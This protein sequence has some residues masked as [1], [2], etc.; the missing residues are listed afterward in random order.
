MFIITKF[1]M[2]FCICNLKLKLKTN[3]GSSCNS[4]VF[5]FRDGSRYCKNHANVGTE[6]HFGKQHEPSYSY[7]RELRTNQRKD[8]DSSSSPKHHSTTI[9][10]TKKETTTSITIS[11]DDHLCNFF[12]FTWAFVQ[13]E[14]VV[15]QLLFQLL[16][17]MIVRFY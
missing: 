7:C 14:V 6:R 1:I 8:Q 2:I 17:V 5:N 3:S 12:W 13:E 11:N 4:M 15:Y 9:T 10:I 16:Y